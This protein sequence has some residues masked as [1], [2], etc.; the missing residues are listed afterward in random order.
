MTNIIEKYKRTFFD[1][2]ERNNLVFTVTKDKK[3][4]AKEATEI[5]ID[6][7]FVNFTLGKRRIRVPKNNT[8]FLEKNTLMFMNRRDAIS[9]RDKSD[10]LHILKSIAV[11]YH[12]LRKIFNVQGHNELIE[13]LD[14]NI[15]ILIKLHKNKTL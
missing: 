1:L 14:S 12:A 2:T 4:I 8:K 3:Y 10:E 11:D 6:R 5:I 13:R 7:C 15:D 9:Y